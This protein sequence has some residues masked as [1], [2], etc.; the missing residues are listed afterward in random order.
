M[1]VPS[2]LNCFISVLITVFFVYFDLPNFGEKNFK[3]SFISKYSKND[4]SKEMH[5]ICVIICLVSIL[6]I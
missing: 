5:V 4:H 6:F 1:H 2:A 3:R